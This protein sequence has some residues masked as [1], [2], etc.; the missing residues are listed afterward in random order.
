M[1]YR[2]ETERDQRIRRRIVRAAVKRAVTRGEPLI[3]P[4]PASPAADG[5]AAR[6]ELHR[7]DLGG[8]G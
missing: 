6:A 5:E 8:E 7:H 3:R 2:D 4:R 1:D